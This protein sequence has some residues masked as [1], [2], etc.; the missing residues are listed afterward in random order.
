[1]KE[2]AEERKVKEREVKEGAERRSVKGRQS[3]TVKRTAVRVET[4]Q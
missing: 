4:A 3:A 1:M 2:G